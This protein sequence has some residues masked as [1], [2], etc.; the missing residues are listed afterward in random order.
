MAPNAHNFANKHWRF[1]EKKL[2]TVMGQ[3]RDDIP[4][5]LPVVGKKRV[6]ISDYKGMLLNSHFRM[7]FRMMTLFQKVY[8]CFS[9]P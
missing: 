2:T 8:E 4:D 9:F 1:I 3:I 6:I 5:F 7:T